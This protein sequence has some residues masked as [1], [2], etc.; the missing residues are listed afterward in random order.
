MSIVAKIICFGSNFFSNSSAN[1]DE[2]CDVERDRVCLADIGVTLLIL[3]PLS[4]CCAL[5][6][7]LLVAV[8]SSPVP[9]FCA[10][11]PL[12]V[13]VGSS[14]LPPFCALRPLFEAVVSSLLPL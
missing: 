5:C 8:G 10:L 4:R 3:L 13:L 6:P 12:L 14:P 9:P 2:V 1:G 11:C 7:S